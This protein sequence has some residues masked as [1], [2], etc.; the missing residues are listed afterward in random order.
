MRLTDAPHI[1][2]EPLIYRIELK[3]PTAREKVPFTS[4]FKELNDSAGLNR[5]SGYLGGWGADGLMGKGTWTLWDLGNS[6]CA[7]RGGNSR[8]TNGQKRLKCRLQNS[9]CVS[10]FVSYSSIKK[11]LEVKAQFICCVDVRLCSRAF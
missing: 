1:T 2:R 10:L 6:P 9:V 7:D 8:G 3:E 4:L 5:I 11:S